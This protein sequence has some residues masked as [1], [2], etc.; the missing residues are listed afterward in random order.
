[1]KYHFQRANTV[2]MIVATIQPYK[3]HPVKDALSKVEVNRLTVCD[4]EGQGQQRGMT[5]TFRGN[6][7]DVQLISKVQLEIVVNDDFLER[8]LDILIDV[9]RTGADGNIGDGKIFILPVAESIRISD[10]KRGPEA[11]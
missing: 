2:K 3:L 4:A 8:T 9:A 6:E 5:A 1:M 10:G 7:Y 11:V